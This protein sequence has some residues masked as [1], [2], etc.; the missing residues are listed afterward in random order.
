MSFIYGQLSL[1]TIGIHVSYL[2]V[3]CTRGDW[4]P[5]GQACPAI[6]VSIRRERRRVLRGDIHLFGRRFFFRFGQR[7]RSSCPS[8]LAR[9]CVISKITNGK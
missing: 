6:A 4:R 8:L 3:Y 1:K 2:R 5:I 7:E 9:F